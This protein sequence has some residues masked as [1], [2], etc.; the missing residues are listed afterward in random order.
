MSTTRN[1][2]AQLEG[3]S[4]L[5]VGGKL[6]AADASSYVVLAPKALASDVVVAKS[7]TGV[8]TITIAPFKGPQ[9]L[10]ATIVSLTGASGIARVDSE[11]YTG[12]SVVVTVKTFAVD[13]TS[14]AD[15]AFSF[16]ILAV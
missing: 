15:K 1:S 6:T 12:D 7:G 16:H 8:Y 13:G 10:I 4:A 14:A 5:Y 11:T 9:G 2:L 3:A